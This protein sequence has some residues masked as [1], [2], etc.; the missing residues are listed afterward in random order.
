[1]RAEAD[2]RDVLVGIR[3]DGRVDIA[4]F[5]EMGVA[6]SHRLQLGCEQAAEVFLFFGGGAG[7]RGRVGLGVDHDV[8][9]KALGH[10]VR[11]PEG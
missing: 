11:E 9:Q 8:A 1:M 5:V 3:R 10:G 7:R 6:K 2:D 4:V